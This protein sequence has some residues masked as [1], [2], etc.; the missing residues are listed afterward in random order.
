M[1]IG[2]S[3]FATALA[4]IDGRAHA[5]VTAW[6]RATYGVAFVDRVTEP[7]IDAVLAAGDAIE[8]DSLRRKAALSV[9]AHGA[10]VIAVVGH[11]DCAANPGSAEQ[12]R[13][14]I[15]AAVAEVESW[16]LP[17]K[18]IGLWVN[19]SW[20]VEPVAADASESPREAVSHAATS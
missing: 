11:H 15:R 2:T 7:G 8:R 4:C 9:T 14:Q 18:V 19:D 16:S 20:E 13:A 6:L 12:H 1:I 17:A 10:R 3:S 5:P